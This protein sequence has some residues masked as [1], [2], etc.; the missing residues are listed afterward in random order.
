MGPPPI[1]AALKL[2]G[3]EL[4]CQPST[5]LDPV[6]IIFH[7]LPNSD[8]PSRATQLLNSP[9]SRTCSHP[10]RYFSGRDETHPTRPRHRPKCIAA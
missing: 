8:T 4:A 5:F 10:Q 9:F 7:R 2:Y 1:S 6:V 3:H